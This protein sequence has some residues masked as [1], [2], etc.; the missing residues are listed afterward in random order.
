MELKLRDLLFYKKFLL[1]VKKSERSLEKKKWERRK[2]E[3]K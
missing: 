1:K 2:C 3:K